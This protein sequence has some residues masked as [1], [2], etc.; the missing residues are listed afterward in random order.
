[1]AKNILTRDSQFTVRE[2]KILAYILLVIFTGLFLF[3]I[4]YGITNNDVTAMVI[5]VFGAGPAFLFFNKARS[6][7]V[8]IRVNIRGIYMDE[9]LLTSWDNYLKA[10]ITQKQKAFAI[11][12]NF[13][14]VVEYRKKDDPKTGLR[15]QIALTNTQNQSEEDV[16]AAIQFFF[17][18]FQRGKM[19]NV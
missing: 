1:M 4:I 7:R 5:S 6:T 18:E 8:Y 9:V 11:Q 14:L 19:L 13:V 10:Y 2:E 15:K 3:L 16:L 17:R 12:D